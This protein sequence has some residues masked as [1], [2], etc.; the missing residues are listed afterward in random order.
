LDGADA[1]G[2]YGPAWI[3][4]VATHRLGERGI[5]DTARLGIHHELSSLIWNSV[6]DLPARWRAL[7][8][9]G[10]SDAQDNAEALRSAEP[11]AADPDRGFLSPYG[12]TTA[13]NDFNVYAETVF[14]EPARLAA[15]AKSHELIAQKMALLI[16]AYTSVDSRLAEVFHQ[17]GVA[18]LGLDASGRVP[19]SN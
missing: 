2:T 4:L 5:H 17:L 9:S 12:A 6:L 8:P 3:I 1:G 14:T 7:L 19:H 10:W 13:E 16:D 11:G 15:L 18:S